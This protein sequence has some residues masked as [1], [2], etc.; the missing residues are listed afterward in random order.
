MKRAC[1][2]ALCAALL[3]AT[4]HATEAPCTA[5][6]SWAKFKQL[7]LSDDGRVVD[8]STEQ[9]ITV[10]EGQAYALLFALVGNDRTGFDTVLEWT[11]NNLAHGDLG[12]SLPAWKWGRAAD[13]R[14]TVLD[15]NSASDADVWMSYALAE[16]ARLWHVEAYGNI[17]RAL[18][19]SI[20]REE[21]ALV[22]G[23]GSA[24]LPG[25]RGFVSG[26]IWRLNASYSPIQA[27]RLVARQSGNPLWDEVLASSVRVIF[28][29][30]PRGYAA[31]WVAY[32][33]NEG[34]FTDPVTHGVGSYDAI[35]VYLWSGTL[36]DADPQT[37]PLA[38]AL[39]PMIGSAAKHPVPESIDTT[40]I[41]VHGEGSPG[42]VAA[43]LPSLERSKAN[44][45]VQGA[46]AQIEATALKNNQHYYSDALTLFGL[47][48]LD[49]RYHF[50]R[51]GRL[52]VPW[53]GPCRAR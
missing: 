37:Q 30:A 43:L 33:S 52:Q 34:F 45:A 22:P 1:H 49:G 40:R 20:L 2:W 13:G 41:E 26:E 23:L 42:F 48:W 14:W 17:S 31:D 53:T 29:S 6:P 36:A 7:Y 28:A 21:V 9:R 35:R 18:S 50:D 19:E 38:H 15:P 10:S 11:R 8:A 16:A 24:L 3:T 25:P 27:L 12:H 4:V 51:Q 47:G 32:R 46:R 44:A 5:W 39:E